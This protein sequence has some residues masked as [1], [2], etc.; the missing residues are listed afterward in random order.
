MATTIFILG[1]TPVKIDTKDKTLSI[2]DALEQQDIELD[3]S[4]KI[5]A[6]KDGK[7][8]NVVKPTAKIYQYKELMVMGK[9]DGSY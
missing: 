5:K 2:A 8:F 7:L 9:V 3:K 6:S 4:T 1:N